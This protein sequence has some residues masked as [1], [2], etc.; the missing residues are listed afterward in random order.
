MYHFHLNVWGFAHAHWQ[1]EVA[2][3]P[4]WRG[5]GT[6]FCEGLTEFQSKR[7]LSNPNPNG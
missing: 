3:E 7:N 4:E 2:V 6:R 1:A 5:E